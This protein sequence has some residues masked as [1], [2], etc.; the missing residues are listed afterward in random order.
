MRVAFEGEATYR[1]REARDWRREIGRAIHA[2]ELLRLSGRD[3]VLRRWPDLLDPH[4]GDRFFLARS[5]LPEVER[6]AESMRR[7]HPKA[8][9]TVPPELEETSARQ[10]REVTAAS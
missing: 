4:P 5:P 2:G 6:L 3:D 7:Q 1:L 9:V 8:E 10:V